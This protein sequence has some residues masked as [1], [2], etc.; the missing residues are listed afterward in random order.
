MI[1]PV[2]ALAASAALAACAGALALVRG[3][4]L[5]VTVQGGSMYPTLSDGDRLLMRRRP[6]DGPLARDAIV[7]V[8]APD[9]TGGPLYVKRVAAAPGDRLPS[10]AGRVEADHYFLLGDHEHSRDSRAWGCVPGSHIVAVASRRRT[11][12]P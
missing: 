4:F 6:P 2:A 9:E 7:A 8:H 5:L 11:G 12:T 1:C 3:R 10:E